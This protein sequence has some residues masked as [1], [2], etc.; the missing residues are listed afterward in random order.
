MCNRGALPIKLVRN[1]M[2]YESMLAETIA[3]RGHRG[4]LGEA[5]YARPLGPAPGPAWCSSITCRAGTNGS[6]RRRASSRITDLRPSRRISISAKGP[7]APTTSARGY[8]RR[9]ASPTSR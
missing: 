1:G 6:R 3:F 7:A 9:A 8:A 4:D 2:T 5:Y